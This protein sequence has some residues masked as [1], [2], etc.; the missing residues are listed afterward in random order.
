[1]DYKHNISDPLMPRNEGYQYA[2][3]GQTNL[4][5]LSL[6]RQDKQILV[7]IT[8]QSNGDFVGGVAIIPP[9]VMRDGQPVT[10]YLH[11]FLAVGIGVRVGHSIRTRPHDIINTPYRDAA[12]GQIKVKKVVQ[13]IALDEGL[14]QTMFDYYTGKFPYGIITVM[15][16]DKT[17]G[18][19]EQFAK[20]LMNRTQGN[21]K[22][23]A[24]WK[25]NVISFSEQ[26]LMDKRTNTIVGWAPS[27]VFP[28]FRFQLYGRRIVQ[29]EPAVDHTRA[30]I[31]DAI[32]T[33]LDKVGVKA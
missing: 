3:L 21:D 25:D 6:C 14:V 10:K 32:G 15:R 1:M 13:A 7:G 12:S 8:R 29:P 24:G 22:E 5:S 31:E 11:H 28:D 26:A 30:T 17:I 33:V 9:T 16:N 4:Q 2:S 23:V 19:S 18:T 27:E 20:S